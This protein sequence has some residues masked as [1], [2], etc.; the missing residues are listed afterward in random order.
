MDRTAPIE[1]MICKVEEIQMFLLANLEE[2]HQLKEPQL[3]TFALIKLTNTGLY[4][5][6][7]ERWSTRDITDRKT[8][9][10][11]RTFMIGE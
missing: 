1:V 2:D 10:D 7:I 4:V 5:K 11:F 6:A 8:W 9:A 3:I